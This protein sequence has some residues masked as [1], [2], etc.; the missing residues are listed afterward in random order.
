MAQDS[1]TPD[2]PDVVQCLEEWRPTCP[3]HSELDWADASALGLWFNESGSSLQLWNDSNSG[4]LLHFIGPLPREPDAP[5]PRLCPF[6]CY[7]WPDWRPKCYTQIFC[8]SGMW[9]VRSGPGGHDHS[10]L[11]H[12]NS[13]RNWRTAPIPSLFPNLAHKSPPYLECQQD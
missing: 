3:G 4:Q 7:S 9:F 10:W 1:L 12:F 2:W 11:L 6:L 8:T 5:P 13:H